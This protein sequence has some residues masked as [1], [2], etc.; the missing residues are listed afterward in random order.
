MAAMELLSIFWLFTKADLPSIIIPCTMFGVF[1]A[2]S[3]LQL[4]S[5]A[6]PSFTDVLARAPLALLYNWSNMLVWTLAN[7]RLPESIK[8]DSVNKPWRAIASGK[9]TPDQARRAM[10]VLVPTVLVLNMLMGVGWETAL[11]V[12]LNWLYNDLGGGDEL[13]RDFMIVLAYSISNYGSLK[14]A[15]DPELAVITEGGYLW[16]A[17]I[18][19]AILTTAHIQD[20]KDQE[21]DRARGRLTVPLILGD[22]FCRWISAICIALWSCACI[23]FWSINLT[24]IFTC[25]PLSC[26]VIYRCIYMRNQQADKNTFRWW[27]LWMMSLYLLPVIYRIQED[28]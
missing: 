22:A 6:N 13:T 16:I 8:E 15:I 23:A 3:G 2:L 9:V 12:I 5:H 26:Y 4:T 10:L 21:G 27:S 25:A 20:L 17:I 19:G 18:G 7:Q 24:N 14:I 11:V 1:S 28:S